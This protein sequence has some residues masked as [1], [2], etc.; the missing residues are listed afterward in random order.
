MA[1]MM[2]ECFETHC[3]NA[4][5]G[6]R[7]QAYGKSPF[8]KYLRFQSDALEFSRCQMKGVEQDDKK[9]LASRN[10]ILRKTSRKICMPALWREFCG[11]KFFWHSAI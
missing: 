3:H 5:L 2:A 9:K 8:P 4:I 6:P 11:I 7:A 10:R 1:L